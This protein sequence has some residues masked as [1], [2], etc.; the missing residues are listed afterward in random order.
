MSPS[1]SHDDL[2]RLAR[3]NTRVTLAPAP[4][5]LLAIFVAGKVVNTQ[6]ARLGW[7]GDVKYKTA[8]KE[9]VYEELRAAGWWCRMFV[10]DGHA[11]ATGGKVGSGPIITARALKDVRLIAHVAGRFDETEGLRA[12][13]KPIPDAL[14]QAGVVSG[15]GAQDGHTWAYKQVV[16][17]TRGAKRGVEIRVR[18]REGA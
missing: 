13:L 1:I 8:W 15:D 5:E 18:L 12:A 4:G 10:V 14:T 17:R 6:N 16:D 11:V 2:K 7:R 3:G 9:R